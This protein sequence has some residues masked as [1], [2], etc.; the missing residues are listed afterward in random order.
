MRGK[1]WKLTAATLVDEWDR[2]FA[3]FDRNREAKF[4]LTLD[5]LEVWGRRNFTVLELGSGPGASARRILERFPRSR[6]VNIDSSPR[7]LRIGEVALSS[8]GKRVSWVVAELGKPGWERSLPVRHAEAAVSSYALHALKREQ[9]WC[10]YRTVGKLLR[11]GGMLINADFMGWEVSQE[12][13]EELSK[14]VQRLRS[15]LPS[16]KREVRDLMSARRSWEAKVQEI[17]ELRALVDSVPASKQSGG[18]PGRLLPLETHLKLLNRAGFRN[19]T[20]LWQDRDVRMVVA[21][22]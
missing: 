17:P 18:D 5:L 22:R 20:V 3:G 6:V 9:L 21:L 15:A 12:M 13:I 19:A 4:D 8:F 7:T 16:R 14:R 11:P 10:V 2:I 1:G